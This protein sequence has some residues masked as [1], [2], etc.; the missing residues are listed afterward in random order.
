MPERQGSLTDRRGESPRHGLASLGA[1]VFDR[2]L[3][4]TVVGSFS[5]V[6]YRSRERL[7]DWPAMPGGSMEGRVALV[8]GATSGIGRVV[9]TALAA[10]GATVL[11]CGRDPDK[12][13]SVVAEFNGDR[14]GQ[15]HGQALGEVAD[16]S[17]L[18]ATRAMARRVA[19]AYPR[20]DVLIHCAGGLQRERKR[21]Q[22]GYELT[23]ATHVLAPFLITAELTGA[24]SAAA[25]SRVITVTSG[26]AYASR[27][28]VSEL[29]S[30]PEPYRG[31]KVYSQAKRAQIVL[32]AEWARRLGPSGVAA[33]VMHPG[34]V[35]TPGLVAGMPGFH[36]VM[37]PVLR[38]PEHGADTVIWLASAAPG[39][40]GTG[41]LWLD[42][43][44][45][46]AYHVPRT[47]ESAGERSALW[48]WCER[49]CR[50]AA[51]A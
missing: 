38:S 20:L 19:A 50:V 18:S 14:P 17:S 3:E 27:L 49:A 46:S 8:T 21:S 33:H 42:R 25:P 29:E 47:R 23:A 9:A 31:A 6:G 35:D 48:A 22:D 34:W 51:D 7:W 41:Q 12:V 4:A 2:V 37:G 1:T 13:A 16:L 10:A 44:V 26:G 30:P 45:R 11:V 32:T 15:A 24:L 28:S 40:L 39:L 5:D 43:R 36:K